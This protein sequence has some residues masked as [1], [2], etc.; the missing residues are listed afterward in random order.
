MLVREPGVHH[1]HRVH[2]THT[3]THTHTH[4]HGTGLARSVS[5]PRCGASLDHTFNSLTTSPPSAAACCTTSS[6]MQPNAYLCAFVVRQATAV[7]ATHTYMS[8]AV[9]VRC[10]ASTS[11]AAYSSV[12]PTGVAAAR[13]RVKPCD[14]RLKPQ[15]AMRGLPWSSRSTLPG[16]RSPCMMPRPCRCTRPWSAPHVYILRQPTTTLPKA[17]GQPRTRKMLC[18]TRHASATVC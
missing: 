18:S 12:N 14:T 2:I 17:A 16:F 15:S 9:D 10:P 5:Q 13:V 1:T 8:D 11:G 7:A 6:T 4:T 3:R